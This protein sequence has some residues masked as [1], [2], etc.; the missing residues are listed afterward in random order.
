MEKKTKDNTTENITEN[1]KVSVTKRVTVYL[2]AA[3]ILV[4]AFS[5]LVTEKKDFSESE[6]RKLASWPEFS[7]AALRS[8][9]LTEGVKSYVS[10]H[11]PKRDELLGIASG[12]K[13]LAG[14]KELGGVYLAEDGYLINAYEAP[15]NV[16]KDIAQWSKLAEKVEHAHVSLM[17]VPTAVSIYKDKLPANAPDRVAQE[18]YGLKSERPM[19]ELP[20]AVQ[21]QTID[22]IYGEIQG[23]ADCI[24]ASAALHAAAGGEGRD[25]SDAYGDMAPVMEGMMS[26]VNGEALFYRTDHHWTT[27]GAYVGYLAFCASEGLAPVPLSEYACET[28]TKDFQG[29][30]YSK[31]NDPYF[32]SDEIVL[33]SDPSWQLTVDYGDAQSDSPYDL[34]YLEKRDKYSLFL[35]NQRSFITITND[36]VEEEAGAIAL[37]KD[38]YANSFVPFLLN[39]Y[40]TVYIFDTRY[41]KGGPSKF[42]NEHPEISEVLILYNLGTLDQDTGIGGI[43]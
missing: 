37:V 33:Y 41:Y 22:R 26:S 17:L 23:K 10:D 14:Q 38:S 6:N 36:A 30:I 27:D 19:G 43:Y 9:S 2:I 32:G 4:F 24:N 21:Q 13:R 34:N 16:E 11:F 18:M 8:G 29:T 7:F 42:I 12:A 39:H 31:L 20:A 5:F 25:A 28:V 35:S 3:M 40:H 1:E 15:K